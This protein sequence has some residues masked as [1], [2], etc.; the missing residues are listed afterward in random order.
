MHRPRFFGATH[1]DLSVCE[2]ITQVRS[3]CSW[4]LPCVSSLVP[5]VLHLSD[6]F[7]CSLAG[8]PAVYAFTQQLG[9]YTNNNVMSWRMQRTMFCRSVLQHWTASP[10]KEGCHW[11]AGGENCQTWQLANPALAHHCYH[12]HPLCL[13]I[14]T[15]EH[16]FKIF[17]QSGIHTVLLFPYQTLWQYSDGDPVAVLG[18]SLGGHWDGDTFIGGRGTQL[19]LSC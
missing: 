9:P 16:I 1:V 2:S 3:M 13:S 17:L 8:L 19:I 14:E 4:T 11:Q 6:G 10:T 5:Y 7:Q 18:F 12:W 15:N